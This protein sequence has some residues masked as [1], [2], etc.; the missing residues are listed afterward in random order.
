[1]QMLHLMLKKN[2]QRKKNYAKV[3]KEINIENKN[4]N[5]KNK[6]KIE[7]NKE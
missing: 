4:I 7:I 3:N 2:S 1:M 6:T 5:N